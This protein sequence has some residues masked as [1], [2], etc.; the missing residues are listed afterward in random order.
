MEITDQLLGQGPGPCR[1]SSPQCCELLA[2]SEAH[3]EAHSSGVTTHFGGN[4]P[5]GCPYLMHI[6]TKRGPATTQ[7]WEPHG[8]GDR[9]IELEEVTVPSRIIKMEK[10]DTLKCW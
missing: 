5:P 8:T 9:E 3:L 2:A 10:I 4:L 1:H 7:L 6:S